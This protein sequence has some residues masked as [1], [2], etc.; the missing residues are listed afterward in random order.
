[1]RKL[2]EK[3][4][5]IWQSFHIFEIFS[6]FF[7]W[8]CNIQSF[9]C[10]LDKFLLFEIV[11][12]DICWPTLHSKPHIMLK[13]LSYLHNITLKH[14]HLPR[15]VRPPSQPVTCD[16]ICVW[17]TTKAIRWFTASQC[18][19]SNKLIFSFT[20]NQSI[21]GIA[22]VNTWKANHNCITELICL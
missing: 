22:K 19:L 9:R 14:S 11:F 10:F 4:M 20:K 3:I 21:N 15:S 7:C 18:K 16:T 12:V 1:M 13:L 6:L 5:K 8:N 2:F 17:H